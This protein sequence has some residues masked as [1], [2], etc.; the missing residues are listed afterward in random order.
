LRLCGPFLLRL[1]MCHLVALWTAVD[2]CGPLCC[3]VHGH[4]ADGVQSAGRSV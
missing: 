3:A 4:I 1:A 2:R